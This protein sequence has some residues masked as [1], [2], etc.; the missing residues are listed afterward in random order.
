MPY[1][2]RDHTVPQPRALEQ[3]SH[4]EQRKLITAQQVEQRALVKQQQY[5]AN[6]PMIKLA[7]KDLKESRKAMHKY[8]MQMGVKNNKLH[9]KGY[10]GEGEVN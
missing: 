2:A 1:L 9:P 7:N 6:A 3:D 5:E 4:R 10:D 8:N